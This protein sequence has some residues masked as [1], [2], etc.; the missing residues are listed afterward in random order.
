M[1]DGTQIQPSRSLVR[2]EAGPSARLDLAEGVDGTAP[3]VGCL[4]YV[5]TPLM[6]STWPWVDI[7]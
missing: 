6:P 3:S 1:A 2:P 4:G 5:C 7:L